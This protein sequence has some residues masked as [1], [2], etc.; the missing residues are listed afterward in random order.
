MQYEQSLLQ[1]VPIFK[2][3]YPQH[4]Y[5]RVPGHG[6]IKAPLFWVRNKIFFP[7]LIGSSDEDTDL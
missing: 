5:D 6:L 2:I 7:F 1:N 3:W 4:V